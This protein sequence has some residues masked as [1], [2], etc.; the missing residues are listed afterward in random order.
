MTVEVG[1]RGDER[2]FR[3]F[4]K[5]GFVPSTTTDK[6]FAG[7]MFPDVAPPTTN[8][9]WNLCM[10]AFVTEGIGSSFEAEGAVCDDVTPCHGF[11][12]TT[13]R[14]ATSS[15]VLHCTAPEGAF[16]TRL[17]RTFLCPT[18]ELSHPSHG[19]DG[20]GKPLALPTMA[21]C[22]GPQRLARDKP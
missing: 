11:G 22:P 16:P 9:A 17:V 21:A 5:D 3:V 6:C 8:P 18:G 4:Q 13:Q 2:K 20:I 12:V 10:R 7:R 15:M 14:Q 1:L 19:S